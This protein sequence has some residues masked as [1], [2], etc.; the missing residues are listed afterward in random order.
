MEVDVS[1]SLGSNQSR[2]SK[3][4]KMVNPSLTGLMK[5]VNKEPY[6]DEIV[7]RGSETSKKDLIY[8]ETADC[9]LPF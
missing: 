1:A 2:F 7:E 8:L 4:L 6:N 5:I 3:H 9:D